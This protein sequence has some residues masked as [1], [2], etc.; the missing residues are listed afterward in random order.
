MKHVYFPLWS[1]AAAAMLLLPGRVAAQDTMPGGKAPATLVCKDGSQET[2]HGKQACAN[3]GGVDSAATQAAMRA[4]G[5]AGQAHPELVI[6]VDGSS[7]P[8]GPTAC[9]NHGGV[10]S[11]ATRAA[12]NQRFHGQ[13]AEGQPPSPDNTESDTVRVRPP[14]PGAAGGDT[15]PNAE[16]P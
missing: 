9:R 15:T 3:H 16:S 5:G 8:S 11:L 14:G 1:L 13:D 12:M 6:C 2:G 7:A 4:R 10:D